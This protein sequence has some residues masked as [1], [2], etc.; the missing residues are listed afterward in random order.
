MIVLD[1]TPPVI[2]ALRDKP[3][4]ASGWNN[5]AVTI[6]FSCSDVTSGV[7]TCPPPITVTTEG[8]NQRISGKAI[9]RA[10]NAA[11]TT[12]IINLDMTPPVVTAS[13]AP[14]P[15]SRGWSHTDVQVSFV[16]TDNLSGVGSVTPPV[17]IS[18][19][20]ANQRVTGTAV[21]IA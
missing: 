21:D 7:L 11:T 12:V 20:G 18:T 16:A 6:A 1:N 19:E 8:A 15:N 14:P 13:Q 10:G 2:T 5:S 3:A 9:D 17:V 4:N